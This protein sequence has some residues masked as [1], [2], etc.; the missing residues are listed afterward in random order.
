MLSIAASFSSGVGRLAH[1]LLPYKFPGLFVIGD[2]PIGCRNEDKIGHLVWVGDEESISTS[3]HENP[4]EN[5][6][7]FC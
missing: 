1:S 7:K 2:Q 3:I 6:E 4:A 5:T